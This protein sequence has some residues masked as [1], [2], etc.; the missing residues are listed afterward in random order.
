MKPTLAVI[1]SAQLLATFWRDCYFKTRLR[2][3]FNLWVR[4]LQVLVT[5]LQTVHDADEVH[6]LDV[7]TNMGPTVMMTTQD[8]NK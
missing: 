1:P 3:A 8:T 5:V 7:L 2:L 4:C 6:F